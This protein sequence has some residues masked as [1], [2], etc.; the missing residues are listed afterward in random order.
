MKIKDILEKI[1]VTS[2]NIPDEL[3]RRTV[4]SL[5][6]NS[7]HACPTCAFFCKRGA[8]TDG[9][10]YA[11]SAYVNGARIFV[12]ERPLDLPED[13]AVI[14]TPNAS[15]ALATLAVDFY[16]D[17][18]KNLRLVGITGT[19]GKTTVAISLYNIASACGINC[20]YI[21][22]N[23]I[24]YGG[25]RLET[26]NTTPDVVQLQ[27][28]LSQMLEAGV[29]T[30]FI[31]VSSQA[32]WQDRIYGLCFETCV[33]TNLYTDHIGGCEHPTFEHYRD[34]KKRLLTDYC[35]ENIIIN[36]DS[37]YC[38]FMLDG[39]EDKNIVRVS[40]TGNTNCNIFAKRAMMLKSGIIPGIS[41]ECCLG[42]G[43]KK[44]DI[45][46]SMPGIYNVE[47]AL[48]TIA[49]CL[50]LGM[51]FSKIAKCLSTLKVDGRFET[52]K[53]TSRPRS[54][55]IIDYAHNGASLCAV[56]NSLRE[57]QPKRIICLFG[58]VGG[59]T[60]GRRRELGEAARDNA[61]ILIITSDN[62]DREDPMSVIN[63]INAAVG[64]TDKPVYLIP[65]RRDAINKAVE[66]ATDG[67]YILLA[68]KGHETYQLINGTRV[69]FSERRI[70]ELADVIYSADV[71]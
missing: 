70:L 1:E 6:H 21:G 48:L 4:L 36:A 37:E 38:D 15:L 20:G 65:D 11:Y 62:P 53:L 34:C 23:G 5:C 3:Y 32:I 42:K 67:D 14:I 60:F 33:F 12:A 25:K 52:V 69:D 16:N 39:V 9:H 57:Y 58:S 51:E 13:A 47:N 46:M 45:F 61:D 63:E 59:R 22:T 50:S 71:K 43:G 19:K 24:Y 8:V 17:P 7:A 2:Y 30:V 44:K 29:E 68:G 27:Q 35:A 26:A 40:A 28:T 66:I 64:Y 55:F 56:L 18:S 31:E 41:F 49:V 10:M 54:L